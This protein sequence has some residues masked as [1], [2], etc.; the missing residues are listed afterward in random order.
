MKHVKSLAL[1]LLALA[2]TFNTQNLISDPYFWIFPILALTECVELL[3][4]RLPKK[5]ASIPEQA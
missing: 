2:I 5:N 1:C 3:L 4:D